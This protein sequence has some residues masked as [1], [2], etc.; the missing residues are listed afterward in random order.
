[1][2]ETTPQT[3]GP[4]APRQRTERALRVVTGSD[5]VREEITTE[6][7]ADRYEADETGHYRVSRSYAENADGVRITK[8]SRKEILS[9]RAE[10]TAA[11]ADDT[12]EPYPI[13]ATETTDRSRPVVTYYDLRLSRGDEGPVVVD[14][15]AAEDFDKLAWLDR[16]EVAQIPQ[17]LAATGQTARGDIVTSIR[18]GSDRFPTIPAYSRLGW[19]FRD[20]RWLYV[21][22][23]GAW[24]KAG[25]LDVPVYGNGLGVFSMA[26]PPEDETAGR[27]AFE[28]LWRLFDMT[29][30]KFAAVEIGAVFRAAMGRPSGSCTYVAV[31]RSGKSGHM[32]FVTQCWAPSVRWNTLPFNA[33]K[34]FATP[35]YVEYVHHTFGD[36]FVG[37]DDMAP[38]GSARERAD[39]FD[40]FSRSLF[41]G[42]SKGRM[43]IKD[44]KIVAR[45]RLRPRAFGG[46][47]AE[48]VTAVES[49]QN[50]THLL[51][52]SRGEFDAKAF[53]AADEDGG[54]EARSALMSAF[55]IWWAARMP[56]HSYVSEIEHRFA[57]DLTATTE[58]PGRYVESSADKAAGLFC[59]LEFA[60]SR[61]WVT[62]DRAREL[63]ERAWA[64]LVE[65]LRAQVDAG[66]G[67]SMADR[68][69]DA[70]LDGLAVAAVHVQD[71]RG[72]APAG[73]TGLGWR[74][75]YAQGP[76]IG[77]TDGKR[78][79]L[80]PSAAAPFVIQHSADS[81]APIEITARAMGEALETVG[82]ITGEDE[83]RGGR[84]THRHTTS[85]WIPAVRAAKKVWSMPLPVETDEGNDGPED[86][87]QAPQGPAG[88]TDGLTCRGCGHPMPADLYGDGLHATCT[89]PDEWPAGSLGAVAAAEDR[90]LAAVPA[91]AAP[92]A[93]LAVP[94]AVPA[95]PVAVDEPVTPEPV[96]APAPARQ[97]Q[98]KPRP[99]P[100]VCASIADRVAAALDKAGGDMDKATAALIKTAIPDGMELLESTRVSARYDFTAHPPEPEILRKPSKNGANEVWEARPK[101]TNRNTPDGTEIQALDVNAAYLSALN[102]HLPIGALQHAEGG[103]FDRRRSGL[104]LITPPEWTHTDLPN[105]LGSRELSGD[106]WV[107]RPTLQLSLDAAS[108]RCG[109]LCEAPV[110]HESWTSGS[111]ESILRAFRIILRDA[112]AAA[113][114]G[115]DEV[116][117]AY[118]KAMY[119]KF[120]STSAKASKFNHLIERTDWSQII[121]AQAHGNLWRRAFKAHTAG[122]TVHRITGTDELHVAGDWRA[123]FAEGRGLTEMKTK[124]AYVVGASVAEMGE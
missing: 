104:Y 77:W 2:T 30:D 49:A 85:Q 25:A 31:N 94:V 90:P 64:G 45:D 72:G 111:S 118:V 52:L 42:A 35:A 69:R 66:S 123:V 105:P 89:A 98:R 11:Y 17:V 27:R 3:A 21:H 18:L 29:P 110:I 8:V 22:G 88:G 26:A 34:A 117:L 10:I 63:W 108:E 61:G 107:T 47:S 78:L 119:S 6:R 58:A 57:A 79:F 71:V 67:Q 113:I 38:T 13:A 37:W 16:Q 96:A 116:T 32:A 65:S 106:L 84:I 24:T 7:I 124:G 53:A 39:Y 73:A 101:W 44:N 81:G 48:D 46:L 114:E 99:E 5:G 109:R 95:G 20:G 83:N 82:Y 103:E 102:T 93:P 87:P 50:R 33:G 74:G 92:E 68:I 40:L 51:Q 120:I 62:E 122:L 54:P 36:M 43:G 121:R 9:A 91:Q 56:A 15:V 1:M 97:E 100:Q 12:G 115:G 86:G 70:L 112:R 23:G 19:H 14:T 80:L 59:G 55:V 60:L 41:N 75:E 28:A 4:R 76:G